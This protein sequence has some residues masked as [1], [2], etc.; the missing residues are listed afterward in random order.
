MTAGQYTFRGLVGVILVHADTA[1]VARAESLS[2]LQPSCKQNVRC[3]P[4]SLRRL[5]LH[6]RRRLRCFQFLVGHLCIVQPS[7]QFSVLSRLCLLREELGKYCALRAPLAFR[8]IDDMLPTTLGALSRPLVTASRTCRASRRVL[9]SPVN[10]QIVHPQRQV[11]Y[12]LSVLH[13]G[14]ELRDPRRQTLCHSFQ[15]GE[16]CLHLGLNGAQPSIWMD[17]ET[18][19]R[20]Q[21]RSSCRYPRLHN[22]GVDGFVQGAYALEVRTQHVVCV[23]HAAVCAVIYMKSTAHPA[24]SAP[25]RYIRTLERLHVAPARAARRAA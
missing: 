5:V 16:V 7:C 10:P 20:P 17:T 14:L 11:K 4:R 2:S 24:R 21:L 3:N 8:G 13:L 25:S 9:C 15:A 22:R 1:P 6:D 18:P 23:C 12:V 19:V